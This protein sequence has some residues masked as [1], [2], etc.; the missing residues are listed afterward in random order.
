MRAIRIEEYGGPE[1]L[2][3]VELPEPEAGRG[4]VVVEIA[5]A[6]VN[7]MDVTQ[8]L[9]RYP[10]GGLPAVIGGEGAGTVVAVGEGV[11][12]RAVGDRVAW[13][14]PRGSYAERVALP[15]AQAV[16]VPDDVELEQAAAVMLQGMT[17]HYLAHSTYPLGEGD[18]ALVYAAAGGVGRLLVQIA[19][20]RGA[21]VIGAT[22]SEAKAAEARRLGADEVIVYG[23]GV[24]VAAEARALTDGRGVDVVYDSIG[25]A[26]FEASIGSLRPRGLLA[27]YGAASG[28]IGEIDLDVLSTGGSLFLT[29]AS[30]IRY[31]ATPEELAWRSGDVLG[32]VGAGELDLL[33]HERYPLEDAARAHTDIQSRTTSGKLLLIP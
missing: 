3:L 1:V 25:K 10:G 7:Y 19:K 13:A 28:P 30:L 16:P 17:A 26:T 24:D 11:T 14:G 5:A 6:G 4:Q 21:R 23:E 9:G 18:T 32:W 15:A 2:Q 20:K 22:S 27:S 31:I 12:D 29:R 8:R 33:I